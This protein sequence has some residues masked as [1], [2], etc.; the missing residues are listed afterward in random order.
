MN[1]FE[2][3]DFAKRLGLSVEHEWYHDMMLRVTV[4]RVEFRMPPSFSP[5]NGSERGAL[6][7]TIKF[8]N[9]MGPV[10]YSDACAPAYNSLKQY[11]TWR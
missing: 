10:E 2:L 8:D 6:I 9:S 3:M 4:Q 7:A 5:K 11:E 1:H